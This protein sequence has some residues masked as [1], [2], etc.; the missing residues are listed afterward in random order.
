VLIAAIYS[1]G[2][3]SELSAEKRDYRV[4]LMGCGV[5]S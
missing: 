4:S 5:W 3:G 1:C 2:M